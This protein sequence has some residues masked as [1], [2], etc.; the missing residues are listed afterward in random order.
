MALLI[1]SL[2]LWLTTIFDFP[3]SI[4]GCSS[5]AAIRLP[6]SEGQAPSLSMARNHRSLRA[7]HPL[8]S[9]AIAQ[10]LLDCCVN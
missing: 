8:E 6:E 3:R 10:K 2:L 5:P 4:A 9:C 7:W 1:S